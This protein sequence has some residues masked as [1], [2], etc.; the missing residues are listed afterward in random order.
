MLGSY[1]GVVVA[2]T[3]PVAGNMGSKVVG[4]ELSGL[5]RTMWAHWWTG[6]RLRKDGA[7]PLT[8]PEIAFP[9]EGPFSS[10]APVNDLLSLPLQG[11]FG[12]VPAFNLVV[13]FHLLLALTGGYALA[14]SAGVRRAGAWVSGLVFGL[15]GFLL[16]YGISSAVV[17][18][19]TVGWVAWFLAAMLWLI[20]EPGP[21]PAL[22]TGVFFAIGGLASFYWTVIIAVCLPPL[23]IAAIWAVRQE[24][25]SP[26]E[27]RLWLWIGASILVAAVVFGPPASALMETYID[28][29]AVLE[30]Y[31][32]RKQLLLPANVMAKLAHD[33]ATVAGYLAPGKSQLTWH[34]DMDQLAQTTYAGW[35]ALVFA[36]AAVRPGRWRWLLVALWGAALSLGPFAFITGSAYRTEAVWYWV[37]LRDVFPPVRLITSYVRFSIFFFLGLSVL[38][39]FGVDALVARVRAR[40]AGPWA[41]LAGVGVGGLVI[42]ELFVLSPVIMPLPHAD[43]YSPPVSEVLA[44]LPREGAVLDWPQ[45][46]PDRKVEVSRYFYYQSRHGRPIPYDFA[47]TSYMPSPIEG[48][49]F[50]KRLEL[51]TYGDSYT[52]AAWTD[53]SDFPVARGIEDLE[54]MGFA[55][56]SLHLEFIP[57]ERQSALV[58]WL[59]SNLPLVETGDPSVIVF[60]VVSEERFQLGDL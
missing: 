35:I 7:W 14:R 12:L 57:E 42:A 25:R 3:W 59:A 38:T 9:R 22:A 20:R 29:G 24:G 15:N 51:I 28:G 6:Y 55:Y 5:W 44:E 39:G 60:E 36:A 18:T 19:S 52:S 34:E 49:P 4:H 11:L 21:K 43:A 26:L 40:G 33:F 48:N 58:G 31:A 46:Y 30:D 37:V 2:I 23:A 8:A 10:I 53:I 16:S 1:V 50:F 45:R 13:M 32:E 54:D 27:G 41:R 47:P 17:E 56:V